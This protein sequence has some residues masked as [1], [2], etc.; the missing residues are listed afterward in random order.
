VAAP[1]GGAMT[2]LTP[3]RIFALT[4]AIVLAVLALA[5]WP[6]AQ[7]L[8]AAQVIP[9]ASALPAAPA[10]SLDIAMLQNAAVFNP[11]RSAA[12]PTMAQPSVPA[13][14][15]PDLLGIMRSASG[16]GLAL[17][18]KADGTQALVKQGQSLD[19]WRL[20]V[21]QRQSVTLAQGE[22][23]QSLRIKRETP[24]KTSAEAAAPNQSPETAQ[25][26]PAAAPETSASPTPPPPTSNIL[27]ED[28]KP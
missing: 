5:L 3:P 14:P 15:L 18:R 23:R 17:L 24:P 12:T 2:R 1:I 28:Q 21:L 4:A 16:G 6:R 19:G 20:V 10:S 7:Q 13:A 25:T 26:T 9:R 11:A 22:A 27:P 8:P